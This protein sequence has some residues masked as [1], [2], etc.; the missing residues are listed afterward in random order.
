MTTPTLH[1]FRILL[2][3]D[4]AID[5]IEDRASF[6]PTSVSV[7]ADFAR[8]PSHKQV[9]NT[10]VEFYVS[11]SAFLKSGI[12]RKV[13]ADKKQNPTPV[14]GLDSN[15]EVDAFLSSMCVLVLDLGGTGSLRK[16]LTLSQVQANFDGAGLAAPQLGDQDLRKV[17]LDGK[18]YL[19]GIG[20]YHAYAEVLK[21]CV[22]V[23]V[24]TKHDYTRAEHDPTGVVN[25]L[26]DPFCGR[27]LWRPYTAKHHKNAEDYA[28]L[29]DRLSALY[30]LYNAGFTDADNLADVEIAA[31]HDHPVM[32]V[33]ES[34]TGKEGIAKHIHLRWAQEK[35]RAPSSA[36]EKPS[37]DPPFCSFNCAGLTESLM[38]SQLFGH[39][40]GAFTG[41]ISETEGLLKS[42]D[43]GTLFLDEFGDLSPTAQAKLLRFLQSGQISPVGTPTTSEATVRILTATSDPRFAAF[44]GIH[45]DN[46]DHN[47]PPPLMGQWRSEEELRKPLRA[48]LLSRVKMQTIRVVPVQGGQRGNVERVVKQMVRSREKDASSSLWLDEAIKALVAKFEAQIHKVSEAQK[49][50]EAGDA[51]GKFLFSYPFFGHRREIGQAIDLINSIVQHSRRRGERRE[52]DKVTAADVN[53]V[54][55]PAALLVPSPTALVQPKP[56]VAAPPS[57]YEAKCR[58]DLKAI[59]EQFAVDLAK[60]WTPHQLEILV[61]DSAKLDSTPGAEAKLKKFFLTHPEAPS[62]KGGRKR[63]TEAA[64]IDFL[65]ALGY[66]ADEITQ[67]TPERLIKRVRDWRKDWRKPKS[68]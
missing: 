10:P 21:S 68:S 60:G 46:P 26:M 31:M 29:G 16:E 4:E 41:A 3:D 63:P 32:I 48:D 50:W 19:S 17:Q 51:S 54:F 34:G 30:E 61:K 65:K 8:K 13:S 14:R 9:G 64:K 2:I 23:F 27:I 42:C 35:K 18:D 24:L 12:V 33:G 11:T 49:H 5:G 45:G 1:P 15:A 62:I 6:D 22:A 38:D 53:R 56:P 58:S 67:K 47:A 7:C 36:D 57:S 44:A 40:K 52:N 20:F 55:R 39:A 43:G 59:L 66:S 37:N 25:R 28:L